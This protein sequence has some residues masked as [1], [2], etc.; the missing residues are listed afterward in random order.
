MVAAVAETTWD[1]VDIVAGENCLVGRLRDV[2]SSNK[3]PPASVVKL[4]IDSPATCCTA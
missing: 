4:C 3:L 1:I 2:L